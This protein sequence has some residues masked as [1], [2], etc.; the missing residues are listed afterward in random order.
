MARTKIGCGTTF[1]GAKDRD[2]LDNSF[3]TTE[4]IVV[5]FIPIIP[6]GSL[7]VIS[8]GS[9]NIFNTQYFVLKDNFT[10][11]K[12]IFYTYLISA[13][14]LFIAIKISGYLAS[15]FPN[16]EEKDLVRSIGLFIPLIIAYFGILKP[17]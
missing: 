3:I 11:Y 9:G 17:K 13:I 1:Y 5:F 2:Q 10:D 12:Q 4:W 6:L 15:F 14:S 7:R 16:K 8:D